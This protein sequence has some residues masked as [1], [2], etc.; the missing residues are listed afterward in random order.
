VREQNPLIKYNFSQFEINHESFPFNLQLK[1][2]ISIPVKEKKKSKRILKSFIGTTMSF[3]ALSSRSMAQGL[4]TTAPHQAGML[5]LPVDFT[6][7]MI[8][9]IKMALGASF[10]LAMI[11][12]IAAGSLRMLRKKKEAT[13]W[14]TDIIKGFTQVL[15]SIP[16]IFL[17]FYV[18]VKLLGNLDMFI[19]PF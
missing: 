1:E 7:P 19:K 12:M 2:V 8:M 15:L 10:L 17:I 3:I 6:D 13:E 9:L 4:A 11:L 5:G 16:I 14:T 18:A